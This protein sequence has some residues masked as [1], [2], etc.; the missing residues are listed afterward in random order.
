MSVVSAVLCVKDRAGV[1]AKSVEAVCINSAKLDFLI[2]S[3]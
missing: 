3:S 1:P 2:K